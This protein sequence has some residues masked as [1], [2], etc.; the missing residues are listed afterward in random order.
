MSG[1]HCRIGDFVLHWDLRSNRGFQ[2]NSFK[3]IEIKMHQIN[4]DEVPTLLSELQGIV[5]KHEKLSR[6]YRR[7]VGRVQASPDGLRFAFAFPLPDLQMRV[8]P[9]I[10]NFTPEKTDE[11]FLLRYCLNPPTNPGEV[12]VF[13]RDLIRALNVINNVRKTGTST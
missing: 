5:S 7:Y 8:M 1:S 11:G 3:D 9:A 4:Q 13:C 2:R 6:A 10:S 12:R